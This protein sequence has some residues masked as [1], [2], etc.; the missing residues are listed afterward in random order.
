MAHTV[1]FTLNDNSDGQK[2]RLVR[3]CQTYLKN[4][5]G[6]IYFAAGTLADDL[7]RSVN[8]RDF[9]VSLHLVFRNKAYQDAYQTA[10]AHQEFIQRNQANW[11]QVRVFDSYLR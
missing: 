10:A 4:H 2:A 1:F 9:D 6:V 11:K 5:P 3:E 8:V 7:Q